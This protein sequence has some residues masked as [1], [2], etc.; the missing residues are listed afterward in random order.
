MA[1]TLLAMASNPRANSALLFV[2]LQV[3]LGQAFPHSTATSAN[4]DASRESELCKR[5]RGLYAAQQRFFAMRY[6]TVRTSA[7]SFCQAGLVTGNRNPRHVLF[8]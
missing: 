8:Y 7:R 1:S 6:R 5:R 3:M 2:F 4:R